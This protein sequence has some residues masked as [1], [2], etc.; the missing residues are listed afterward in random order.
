[1]WGVGVGRRRGEG[2]KRKR[3][4]R[5]RL[6]SRTA[7]SLTLHLFQYEVRFY[8]P[9]SLSQSQCCE[10]SHSLATLTENS[11]TRG[12]G[13][14]A[15]G[16]VPREHVISARPLRLLA[17]QACARSTRPGLHVMAAAANDSASYYHSLSRGGMASVDLFPSSFRAAPT[18]L[19]ARLCV[20][21]CVH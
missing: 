11:R 7:L 3:R 18:R 9:F 5:R 8:R 12:T 19:R 21:V 2:E 13:L 4:R 10:A 15:R 16:G 1:M 6:F 14:Q 17:V 20:C